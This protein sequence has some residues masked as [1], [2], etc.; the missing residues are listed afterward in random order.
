MSTVPILDRDDVPEAR[1]APGDWPA[2]IAATDGPQLVVAGPGTGK[3]ELLV[4]RA[5]HLLGSG[6][7]DEASLLL[8]TFS[9]R[10]AA[11]LRRRV[12][13]QLPGPRRPIQASTFHSFA[14]RIVETFGIRDT[15]WASDA[16]PTLLTGPEQVA[17]VAELLATENPAHWP[18]PQRSLLTSPTFAADV[19]DFI[20]RCGER[21]LT[22]DAL[23]R[24]HAERTDWRALP[25]FI[26]RYAAA[27]RQRGRIDYANLVAVAVAAASRPDAAGR[28][29]SQYR[30]VLVD[31]YQDTSPAQAELLRVVAGTAVNITV[32]ADPYQSIY[33][34]RGADLDNVADFPHQFRG[35]DGSPG[36]RI[37]LT[38]S[39]RVPAAVLDGA[40]RITG[41]GR[42]PGGAGPVVPADHPGSVEGY[43][44]DQE[45]AE[46]DWIAAEV[47]RLHLEDGLPLGRMAVLLRSKRRLLPELSR[48]LDRRRIR[49][50][51]PDIRL[52]D[53]PA[54]RVVLDTARAAADITPPDMATGDAAAG[55][56]EADDLVRS[57]LLGPLYGFPLSTERELHRDRRRSG[58]G[59]P[60]VL[61]ARPETTG[62]AA[63]LADGSWAT[64]VSAAEGF[65][66][67]WTTL[68]G[69]GRL[70]ADPAGAGYRAAWA[71][72]SQALNRQEERD[73]SMTLLE[74]AT[75]SRRDDFE[76]TPLLDADTS[77]DERLTLTTLHQAK[78]LEFDVVFIA[79]AVEG[80]FPDLRRS[81]SVLRP[82]HLSPRGADDERRFRL[83][84]EMRL[85]YTAMTRARSR[86]VWT[87]TSAGTGLETER[88]SRFMVPAVGAVSHLDLGLPTPRSGPP[89]TV[90]E[91]ETGLRRSLVDPAT[92]A[93]LRLAALEMLAHPP[94][95]VW[96][97]E[98]FAGV[99]DRG[100]DTGVLPAA[101]RLSPSQAEVYADCPR[102]YALERRIGI[103]DPG[104]PSASFGT[105]I[106]LV[107]ERAEGGAL[108]AGRRRSDLASALAE[109][110]AAW[111]PEPFSPF[112]AV[113]KRKA[114]SLLTD[115][116]ELWPE[117]SENAVALE[118]E[119]ALQLGG[120]AW[121]GRA[122]RIERT[123]QGTLR[124]VDYKTGSK[125]P[126]RTEAASSLQLGYYLLAAR[127]DPSLGGDVAEA[128]AWYPRG[129]L[130]DRRRRFSPENLIDVRTRLEEIAG[131]I[132]AEIWGPSVGE[133]C[134]WCGVKSVCPAWP[135][136][137]EGFVS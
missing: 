132:R 98:R 9:R 27:C 6:L 2:V 103:G 23:R 76:A 116:Y 128:E 20:L 135:V 5:A 137:R 106:H 11:D 43:V 51:T 71:A 74:F 64:G 32:A 83:D 72:L 130:V 123:S 33:G 127:A 77:D 26:E 28:I 114:E 44:F 113:W 21:L 60:E 53:H 108:A 99:S 133:G 102:R 40:L 93:G 52:V 50:D 8:L 45:S 65:W 131:D 109:L 84:E 13:S 105:I 67:L 54:V 4:R 100:P 92:P 112:D 70:V 134:R 88:P 36:R 126:S 63:L 136:G 81:L 42:L 16:L 29:A 7:A 110:E 25:A 22:A 104:T 118:R 10:A 94:L 19:A 1:V 12:R 56:G 69:V 107:L 122:D 62:L 18:L 89:L 34:F 90:R 82:E 125:M 38:T 59:W 17:L 75:L 68:D 24:D 96:H 87:A 78:G 85:A 37:V 66:R 124:I 58:L 117:D 95:P 119:L 129:G 14:S 3:T 55:G 111:D 15:G 79:D 80:G 101:F 91:L 48:S 86:V 61:A 31:E 49:H 115:L 41:P 46:A 97:A 121:T 39:F 73:P 30:Y 120:A 47:E 57:I 35:P